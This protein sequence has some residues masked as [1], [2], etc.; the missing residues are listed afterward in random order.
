MEQ[1]EQVGA[2][3]KEPKIN[4]SPKN[5]GNVTD[6]GDKRC[7]EET[8]EGNSSNSIVVK[9]K[10]VVQSKY[11]CGTL[12]GITVEQ[13]EQYCKAYSNIDY[14]MGNYEI[15]PSTGN[16]HFQCFVGFKKKARPSSFIKSGHWE[17]CKGSKEDNYQ[18]CMKDKSDGKMD[19]SYNFEIPDDIKI[20]KSELKPNQ[21]LLSNLCLF[22]HDLDFK[23]FSRSITWIYDSR[24]EWGKSVWAAH[25]VD[26]HKGLM[27]GGKETDMLYGFYDFIK[28]E[29]KCDNLIINQTF[30]KDKISYNALESL[31]DGNFFN[32]KYESGAIRFARPNIVVLSNNMPDMEMMGSNRFQI[33][34]TEYLDK[35]G[36]VM[37]ELRSSREQARVGSAE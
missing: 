6:G 14:F 5:Q 26:F 33:Y 36:P 20:Y 3:L 32:S 18:Y 7:P 9:K 17:K 23:K 31:K 35:W 1:M 15:C 37:K 8:I 28:K 24:S 16:E 22:E 2:N 11:W 4:K 25:V 27:V 13:L 21:I 19:F 34:D 12:Y 29:G 10:R 30:S